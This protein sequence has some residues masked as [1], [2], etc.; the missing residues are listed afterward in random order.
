MIDQVISRNKR[1]FRSVKPDFEGKELAPLQAA[2]FAMWEQLH[3][4]KRLIK[5]PAIPLALRPSFQE[6]LGIKRQW[7]VMNYDGLLRFCADFEIRGAGSRGQ[8]GSS[9]RVLFRKSK[10]P[11]ES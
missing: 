2:D 3:V 8:I 9:H 10:Y 11:T 1:M 5:E 6:L 7:G 4:E